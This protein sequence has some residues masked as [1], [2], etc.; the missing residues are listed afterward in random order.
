MI[1]INNINEFNEYRNNKIGYFLIEDKPT[2][3][4]HMASCPHINIRFFEQKVMV[5]TIK[6][7]RR[8]KSL[9]TATLLA[10][11]GKTSC[12]PRYNLRKRH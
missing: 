7:L 3:T 6:S 1:N 10:K 12:I 8:K 9:K 2:K 11:K 4:L 5:I